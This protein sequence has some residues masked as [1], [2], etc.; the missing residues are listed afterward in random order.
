MQSFNFIKRIKFYS[1]LSFLVSLIAIN[2]CFGLYKLMGDFDTFPNL[3]WE[4]E[5]VQYSHDEFIKLVPEDA[6]A[7]WNRGVA[8]KGLGNDIEAERNF[9]KSIELGYSP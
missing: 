1:V 4:N 5:N 6:G 2:S 3:D 8:H 7:Y 9:K